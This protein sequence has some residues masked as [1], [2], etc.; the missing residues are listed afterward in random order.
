MLWTRRVGTVS[1]SQMLEKTHAQPTINN[2]NA[3]KS[4]NN[5]LTHIYIQILIDNA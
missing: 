1:N 4:P 3:K 5:F 2:L